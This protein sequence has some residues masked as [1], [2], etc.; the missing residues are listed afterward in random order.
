[1]VSRRIAAPRRIAALILALAVA[2][3][4]NSDNVPQPGADGAGSLPSEV[5]SSVPASPS[6]EPSGGNP[7]AGGAETITGTVTAG[8]EPNC[9]L[10]Q[11]AKGSHLLVFDD[12]SL[13]SEAT[14]GAKVTLT[15]KSKPTM[16]STCQQGVPFIVSAVRG[17]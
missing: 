15:G 10:L 11:D 14:V 17:G 13:R 16:M 9:L 5:P 2:G 1:M 4:A 6:A 3:C 8:V 7:T 12:T